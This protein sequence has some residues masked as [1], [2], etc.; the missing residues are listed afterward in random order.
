LHTAALAE[1]A[2]PPGPVSTP[3]ESS[4]MAI[5]LPDLRT[6]CTSYMSASVTTTVSVPVPDVPGTINPNEEFT[7]SVTATN[8]ALPA[9]IRLANVVY[10]LTC[11]PNTVVQLK[12]PASPPARSSADATAPTLA[13]GSFVSGMFLF[14]TDNA[15]DVGDTDT[16]AGLKGKGLA[17]GAGTIYCHVHADPDL[18]YLLP[19]GLT[20]LNGQRALSVV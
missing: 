18:N 20:N 8:A 17:L 11:S 4:I 7:F 13:V 15:L 9:G 1:Q 19:P 5:S 2:I 6:A 10:H 3:Q 14:P 12:V 16:I